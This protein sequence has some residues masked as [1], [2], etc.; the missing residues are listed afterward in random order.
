[1]PTWLAKQ[2]R[3]LPMELEGWLEEQRMLSLALAMQ[4]SLDTDMAVAPGTMARRNINFEK[5]QV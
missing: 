3:E 5:Y 4:S 2:E 1:M